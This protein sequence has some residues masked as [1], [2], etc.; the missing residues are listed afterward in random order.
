MK[1]ISVIIDSHRRSFDCTID[2]EAQCLLGRLLYKD[3]LGWMMLD[4]SRYPGLGSTVV[5]TDT[6]EAGD[7]GEIVFKSR[8]RGVVAT[9]NPGGGNAY[10]KKNRPSRI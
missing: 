2:E 10:F 6:I 7:G 1:N 9:I 3:E 8:E 5:F 4:L